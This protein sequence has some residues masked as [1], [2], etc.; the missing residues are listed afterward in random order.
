MSSDLEQNNA[1]VVWMAKLTSRSKVLLAK[2]KD[3]PLVEVSAEYRRLESIWENYIEHANRFSIDLRHY[4][5]P[6]NQIMANFAETQEMIEKRSKSTIVEK[7]IEPSMRIAKTVD[8]FL[9]GWGFRKQPLLVPIVNIFF[10]LLKVTKLIA[11]PLP[12]PPLPPP[13]LDGKETCKYCYG[14]KKE[15]C[16][17]CDGTGNKVNLGIYKAV[18]DTCNGSG[19]TACL[20]CAV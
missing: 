4:Q 12:K 2:S 1:F 11:P 15:K 5:E 6:V 16:P 17:V 20:H 8:D 13:S 14:T 9:I 3:A 19:R 10:E 18:C 7:I